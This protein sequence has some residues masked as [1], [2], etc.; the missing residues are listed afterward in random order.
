[1][2]RNIEI[3]ARLEDVDG[4]RKVAEKLAFARPER[5][6]QE[7]TFF[8]AP[9][10][11]LKLRTFGDGRG[12]LIF[13]ERPDDAGPKESAYS[14]H[15]T[16]QPDSLRALLERAFGVRGV[17]RKVRT[18]YMCGRT[19]I[20]LDEVEDLGDFLEH[21]VVLAPGESAEAGH[22]EAEK[23]LAALGID[24]ADLIDRAYIDLL[25]L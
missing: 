5:I 24:S 9:H 21:E 22:V 3:K 20:H 7:D 19:R 15:G 10:G 18:L 14:I 8:N 13:Y 16:S 23:L 2:P 1:M 17:V 12:E 25:E 6:V 4:A 11:R